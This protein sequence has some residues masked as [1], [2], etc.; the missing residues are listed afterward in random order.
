MMDYL[1]LDLS[2]KR[3]ERNVA[4]DAFPNRLDLR[5]LKRFPE[6]VK[7]RTLILLQDTSLEWANGSVKFFLE[8]RGDKLVRPI[9]YLDVDIR[10]A[11]QA[12]VD[13]I[14][15]TVELYVNSDFNDVIFSHRIRSPNA[16][17]MFEDPREAHDR[18][19]ER[20]HEEAHVKN[21]THCVKLDVAN[22]YERIDHHKLQQLLEKRGVPGVITSTLC[23]LL[24][25][26]SLSEGRSYGIPQGL[27]P[28]DYIGNI[29]LLDLDEFL[30]DR[31]LLALRYVDDYRIFCNSDLEGRL[32]LKECCGILSELGL[33]AQPSKSGVVEVG[34][35]DPELKPIMQQFITLK[36]T[37]QKIL[38][39]YLDTDYSGDTVVVGEEEELYEEEKEA[40]LSE[41]DIQAFEELWTEIVDQEVKR[42]SI[43]RFALAGLS[44]GGSSSAKEYVL[45]SLGDFPQI[46]PATVKYLL[47]LG[48][49]RNTGEKLLSFL[50][51]PENIYEWQEMWILYY[52]QAK[53]AFLDG[54]MKRR[55]IAIL[56]DY[57]KH[58]LVRAAVAE[59]I[60]IHGIGSDGAAIKRSLRNEANP[61]V[62]RTLLLGYR[63]LPKTERNYAISYLPPTDWILGL[64]GELVKSET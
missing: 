29:Y 43:L 10:L 13:S 12:L 60:A 25:K 23:G 55:L 27:W 48:Y 47:S 26:F 61:R 21:F 11:Y 1:D 63:L 37:Q 7:E 35:L 33:N 3:M 58:P 16:E 38:V 24:R 17:L 19:I 31:G 2:L 46:V 51:S 32:I 52:F 56:E 50:E 9:A 62:R 20:Q 54:D 36:K 22:Y 42:S 41:F 4:G 28:S 64:V 39:R 18:F 34:S 8:P 5:L 49:E 30:R 15:S 57:R 6:Q 14:A 59:I 40:A 53:E 45:S 44:R